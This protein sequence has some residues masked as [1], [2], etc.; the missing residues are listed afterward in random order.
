MSKE[1]HTYWKDNYQLIVLVA[2]IDWPKDPSH[3]LLYNYVM[4]TLQDEKCDFDPFYKSRY[5]KSLATKGH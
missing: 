1:F 4:I 5:T 3:K 2:Q